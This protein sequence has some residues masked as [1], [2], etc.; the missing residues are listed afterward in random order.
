MLPVPSGPRR[1]AELAWLS[2]V[3]APVCAPSNKPWGTEGFPMPTPTWLSA[4]GLQG[5]GGTG[6]RR[7]QEWRR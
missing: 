4:G 2:H 6:G 7:W 1:A 3:P 5:V